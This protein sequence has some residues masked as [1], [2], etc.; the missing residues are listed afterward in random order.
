MTATASDEIVLES[1]ELPAATLS[2]WSFGQLA[3]MAGLDTATLRKL[4]AALAGDALEYRFQFSEA[5]L[6]DK[7]VL[8]TADSGRGLAQVRSANGP[9]YGRIWDGQL[10]RAVENMNQDNRWT[11]PSEFNRTEGFVVTKANTT[12]FASDRDVFIFLVDEHNPISIGDQTYFRGFYTYN[13]ETGNRSFYVATF[14]YSYVCCNRIIWGARDFEELRM[15]HTSAAPERFLEEAVPALK[16]ISD[17]SPEPIITAIRAAQ[18][19]RV[20]ET[21]KKVAAWLE[22]KGFSRY[23]A[24]T[25]IVMAEQGYT[26]G[27]S[28]DPTNL[29]DLVQGGTAAARSIGNQD[30][31][32]ATE[33]QWSD[34]LRHAGTTI[35]DVEPTSVET[36]AI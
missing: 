8:L 4:P 36:E 17:S 1:R 2:H 20:Q 26:S 32:L 12:L 15:R 7:Q 16:A 10:V 34:L 28:G 35:V 19:T 30:T 14:L 13:S 3:N 27:S 6:D 9:K 33:R 21:P 22:R 25:A 29:W 24:A 18:A 31:R 5:G 23:Q 11:V